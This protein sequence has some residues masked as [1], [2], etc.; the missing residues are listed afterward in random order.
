MPSF[1]E[2]GFPT[3]ESVMQLARSLVNDTFPGVGGA[4][5]RILTDT[6]P[7]TLPYLN[8]AFATLQR[9]L[10]IEGVTFPIKDNVILSNLTPVVKVDPG[11]QVFVGFNGYFDGTSMHPSPQLPSDCMQPLLLQEQTVGTNTPFAPMI[12]PEEGIPS[13]FQGAQIRLWEWRNYALYMPG[14]TNSKNLWLRYTSGQPPLNVPAAS[15]STTAINI[16]DSTD[17]LARL[18]AIQYGRARGAAP[19]VLQ[20]VQLE[21]DG[22]ISDMAEEYVRRAQTVA[23]R[24]PAYGQSGRGGG[25]S[26][27]GQTSSGA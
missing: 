25:S 6:A 9:K 24:R 12:Q 5:G 11:V 19:D 1:Q 8:S 16:L 13:C 18:V 21:T 15:F 14:S 10:R 23:Y 20:G 4:Q 3:I 17:A 26:G 27:L 2:S 7:F 22:I